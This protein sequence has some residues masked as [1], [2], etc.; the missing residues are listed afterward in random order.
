MILLFA[1]MYCLSE[2]RVF[3]PSLF[4]A[5]SIWRVI[6][7]R[8]ASVSVLMMGWIALTMAWRSS[9]VSMVSC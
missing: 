2:L 3:S 5:V 9:V 6:S 8:R 4:T 1:S 7:L